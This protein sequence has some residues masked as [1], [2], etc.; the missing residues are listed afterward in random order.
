VFA[1]KQ[2]EAQQEFWIPA[3]EIRK[4]PKSTFYSRL[5]ETLDDLGFEAEVR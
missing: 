4:S 1:E 2:K 5:Q 3:Q